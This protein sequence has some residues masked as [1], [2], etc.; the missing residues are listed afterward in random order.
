MIRF[1]T[2]LIYLEASLLEL[3]RSILGPRGC[4]I[5]FE[6][7]IKFE[8]RLRALRAKNL[9]R[10]FLSVTQHTRLGLINSLKGYKAQEFL[11]ENLLHRIRF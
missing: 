1:G 9:L 10:Y 8:R 5:F 11:C 2:T 3:L 7:Y 4:Y 6:L